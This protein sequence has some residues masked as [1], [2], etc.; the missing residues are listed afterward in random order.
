MNNQKTKKEKNPIRS[1]KLTID[2]Q[3]VKVPTSIVAEKIL[4]LNL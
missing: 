4:F 1:D 2:E 3:V